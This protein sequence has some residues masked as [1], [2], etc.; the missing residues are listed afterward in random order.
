M[1]TVYLIFWIW[2]EYW[3]FTDFFLFLLPKSK[4]NWLCVFHFIQFY[5]ISNE[6]VGETTDKD[7]PMRSILFLSYIYKHTYR[8][9]SQ[10][11]TQNEITKKKTTCISI[12]YI[13]LSNKIQ[14]NK[15]RILNCAFNFSFHVFQ[16]WTYLW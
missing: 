7:H 2:T 6:I 1:D 10:Y 11:R 8:I 5:S 15:N 4:T 3:I 14:W 16:T 13:N 12:H 9:R